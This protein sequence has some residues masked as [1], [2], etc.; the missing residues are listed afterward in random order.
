[1]KL[2][3]KQFVAI[4]LAPIALIGEAVNDLGFIFNHG[5]VAWRERNKLAIEKN[6]KNAL[7]NWAKKRFE[8]GGIVNELTN[9]VMANDGAT[10]VIREGNKEMVI[11]KNNRI[12]YV[13]ISELKSMP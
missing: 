9:L 5:I 12:P 13:S 8:D 10:V 11:K 6:Q 7:D 2:T 3:L 1:M 4:V